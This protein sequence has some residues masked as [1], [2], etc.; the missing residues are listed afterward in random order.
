MVKGFKNEERGFYWTI[1]IAMVFS[2]LVL[3]QLTI[4]MKLKPISIVLDDARY[5]ASIVFKIVKIE[6]TEE[7]Y[8]LEGYAFDPF[9]RVQYNNYVSGFGESY[10]V[11]SSI[12]IKDENQA[13]VF[14]TSPIAIQD[15]F[16]KDGRSVHYTGFHAKIVKK[17]VPQNWDG[18][19]G[20]IIDNEGAF[21]YTFQTL[22]S[23][24]E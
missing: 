9:S 13:L 2:F 7:F 11:D 3:I 6:E 10:R 21:S 4:S 18:S 17:S 1:A 12:F 15:V 8:L 24:H 5:D 22:E 23:N 20:V 16:D 19:V 14:Y